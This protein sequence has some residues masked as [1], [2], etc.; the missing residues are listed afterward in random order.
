M[1]KTL[2]L[3]SV[4]SSFAFCAQAQYYQQ[5]RTRT[6]TRTVYQNPYQPQPQNMAPY[7]QAQ[8]SSPFY[9]QPYLG[10]DYSYNIV[11]FG[12]DE[13]GDSLDSYYNDKLHTGILSLGAKVHDNFALEAYYKKSTKAKKTNSTL[14]TV[15]VTTELELQS[16]GVDAIFHSPRL[17]YDNRVELIGS[18]GVAW[19]E[20]KVKM[21][22]SSL[23]SAS[24]KDNHIGFRAGAGFQYY[25]ND[26][27]ALRLMG[28]YNNTG[29]D[30]A[31]NLYDI[32]AGVRLYF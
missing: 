15:P 3:A 8:Y 4:I 1:K 7:Q 28:H 18:V 2:L 11:D 19:Y 25:L 24:G 17:G 13:D 10:V 6:I 12:S 22:A 27:V 21:N 9:F 16:F 32:T 14:F 30:D 5:P 26:N 23:G 29:I 31:E 20:L